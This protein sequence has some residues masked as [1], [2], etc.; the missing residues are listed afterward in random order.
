MAEAG[1][2]VDPLGGANRGFRQSHLQKT[3][4]DGGYM[5]KPSSGREGGPK[6]VGGA[7]N[8]NNQEVLGSR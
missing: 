4:Q 6:G 5:G 7:E 3:Q 2:T 1:K 8:Q